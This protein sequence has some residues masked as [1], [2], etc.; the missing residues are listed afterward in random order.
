MPKVK[1]QRLSLAP[2]VTP[3][4][5]QPWFG[6]VYANCTGYAIKNSDGTFKVVNKDVAS[7]YLRDLGISQERD[8]HTTSP[9]DRAILAIHDR[10][11][12]DMT[13]ALAGYQPG[14]FTLPDGRKILITRGPKLLEPVPGEF[15]TIQKFLD[16]MLRDQA[17]YFHGWMRHAVKNLY[18]G[19][20]KK[21]QSLVLA[22]PIDTGKSVCQ[23]LIISP[24]LGGRV[25]KPYAFLAGR[26][27]FNGDWFEC[28]H[29]MLEDETPPRDYETQQLVAAGLKSLSANDDQW[30]HGK[31]LKALTLSPFWRVSV[32]VN[33]NPEAM[34]AIPVNDP[35]LKDKMNVLMTY[36][37]ATKELVNS[38]GGQDHLAA[39]FKAERPAYLYWL[40]NESETPEELRDN[41]YGM[42]AQQHPEIVAAGEE[43]EPHFHLLDAMRKVYQGAADVETNVVEIFQELHDEGV[44]RGILPANVN[45]LGKYLSSITDMG[46]G[47]VKKKRT[48]KGIVYVLNFEGTIGT[49][50]KQP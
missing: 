15:P 5:E 14:V 11:S 4:E 6:R 24:L 17:V 7:T 25:A 18:A 22:G 28:E 13:I 41:R 50:Y 42:K 27:D 31:G 19:E 35:T 43:T 12:V 21:G 39:A 40:L 45:T 34:R 37:D 36:P 1:E 3:D 46:T 44:P 32:S 10:H 9:L 33:N 8:T 38:L 26:T 23:T 47:E 30:C 2:G 16:G 49:S 20:I 48:K 29:L